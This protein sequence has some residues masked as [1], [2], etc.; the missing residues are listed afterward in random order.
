MGGGGRILN[1]S[2]LFEKNKLFSLLFSGNFCGVDKAL[3]EG[4]SRDWDPPVPPTWET[5]D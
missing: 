2:L 5:M 4:T 3:M 1:N